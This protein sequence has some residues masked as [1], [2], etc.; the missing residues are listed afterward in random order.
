MFEERTRR[1]LA[2]I[3]RGSLRGRS[4]RVPRCCDAA[5]EAQFSFSVTVM[6]PDGAD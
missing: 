5:I 2:F 6:V 3:L 4:S 1:D